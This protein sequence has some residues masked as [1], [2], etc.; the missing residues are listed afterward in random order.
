MSETKSN[1][2]QDIVLVGG[3]VRVDENTTA[4]AI[5]IRDGRVV[6]VGDRETVLSQCPGAREVDVAGSVVAP[7]LIDTHPHTLHYALLEAPL[8]DVRHARSWADIVMAVRERAKTTPPGEWVMTTPVGDPH[9]FVNESWRDLAEGVLPDAAALDSATSEHPV[10]VQAWAPTVPNHAV[11]NSA[12][13]ALL[14]I[15]QDTPDA[16][17]G[18]LVEKDAEGRPTGRVSGGVNNYYNHTHNE[19]WAQTWSKIPFIQPQLIPA[20]IGS[21]MAEYNAMGITTIYEGHAMEPEHIGVY[22]ALNEANALTLRVLAA[23]E[24]LG[25]AFGVQTPDE[26]RLAEH[27]ARA[28]ALQ[29]DHGDMFKV[30]GFTMAPTGPAN[31]G[32]LVQREPYTGPFGEETQGHWFIP[33]QLL[34]K[35]L[36]HAAERGLRVNLCGGGLG[37]HDVVLGQLDKLRADGALNGDEQWIFQHA[38]FLDEGQAERYAGHGVQMTVNSGFTY[39]KGDMY[40][41]RMGEQILGDLNPFRRM[42]DA[43]IKVAAST[44]WGPKNPYA[45][46]ALAVTHQLGRGPRRNDGLAQ[47][48][49]RQEAYAMWGRR[50]AE[51]LG[52]PGVGDLRTGRHADL[53]LL[54]R[55]P[56]TCPIE[57]LPGT[58]VTATLVGGRI[59]S[60]ALPGKTA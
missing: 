3:V 24:V 59:V 51:V 13:L 31:N 40:L 22:Q 52:W 39:G 41:E 10:I 60:G 47:K 6:S 4:E 53:V 36:R 33:Q 46:M 57:D 30:R 43:G 16:E 2:G 27:L 37:E 23:P 20:A 34:E 19:W 50:A 38:M 12:A 29:A 55:D 42:I 45:C 14:G 58:Q 49:D 28:E 44:D 7:G 56:V 25:S 48:I 1:A 15:D 35:A 21:A 5:G 9:Y 54:D 26:Q 32:H 17:G 11:F 8:V 18:V